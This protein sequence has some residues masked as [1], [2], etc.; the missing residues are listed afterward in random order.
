[1][2]ATWPETGPPR[3][4]ILAAGASSRLGYPKALAA[5]PRGTPLERLIREWPLKGIRPTV[6]TGAHHREISEALHSIDSPARA[7]RNTGWERGRT[8]SLKAAVE[9]HPDQ[10]LMVAPVDCPRVPGAVFAALLREWS[11]AG[12]P[13][14]GW[15]APFVR[16]TQTRKDLYGHPILI[17]RGL[18]RGVLDMDP[19]DPLRS[20]RMGAEPL[21]GVQVSHAEILED[22]DTPAD[23]EQLRK[24]DLRSP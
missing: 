21:W 8:G 7:V 6:V 4:V 19:D 17:G 15:C 20:L 24:E 3:L 16:R 18:L 11:L 14:Q 9:L 10:D 5:L 2:T 1:M 12:S 13:A 23:L 22:L